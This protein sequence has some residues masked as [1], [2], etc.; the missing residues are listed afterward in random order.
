ME[1][2]LYIIKLQRMIYNSMEINELNSDCLVVEKK[3]EKHLGILRDECD[4][5]FA[6]WLKTK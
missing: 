1:E 6:V 4:N 5:H 3:D 2:S